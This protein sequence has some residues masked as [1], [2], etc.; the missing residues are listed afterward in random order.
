MGDKLSE[1]ETE[2]NYNFR[3]LNKC[4]FKNIFF[5]KEFLLE[6]DLDGDGNINYEEFI[7]MIFKE[8]LRS[9]M[10]IIFIHMINVKC[11]IGNMHVI[12]GRFITEVSM[13][14]TRQNSGK[15]EE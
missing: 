5:P 13:S 11:L 15:E 4:L 8:V 6:A 14:R 2:V 9:I 12:E 3:I 7:T 1:E 10:S